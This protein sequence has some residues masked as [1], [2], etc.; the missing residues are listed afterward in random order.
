MPKDTVPE[1]R[2][3]AQQVVF[4][5]RDDQNIE[6]MPSDLTADVQNMLTTDE[7]EMRER[8]RELEGSTRHEDRSINAHMSESSSAR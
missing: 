5:E 4:P 3:T 7:L 1:H 8:E 2:H 6:K